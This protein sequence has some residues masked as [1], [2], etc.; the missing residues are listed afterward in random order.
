MRKGREGWGEEGRVKEGRR[1]V[2]E[3]EREHSRERQMLRERETGV[4][5]FQPERLGE[6]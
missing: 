2:E 5:A 1:E 4:Q 6:C 3:M